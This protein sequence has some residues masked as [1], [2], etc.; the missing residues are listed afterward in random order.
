MDELE[1]KLPER[2]HVRLSGHDY[3]TPGAYF[4]TICCADMKH[5]FGRVAGDSV[6]LNKLGQIAMAELHRIAEHHNAL[7]DTY[8]VM[9]NHVHAILFLDPARFVE[10]LSAGAPRGAPTAPTRKPPNIGVLVSLYKQ[11]VTRAIRSVLGDAG[12]K[13]W[14]RGFYEHVVRDEDGLN[15]RRYYIQTNPQRWLL[16]NA[17]E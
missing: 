3:S 5:L 2:K 8:I 1:N 12:F 4:I 9:P 13:V 16:K 6:E 7:V 17:S 15:T 14:Q 11:A 10:S